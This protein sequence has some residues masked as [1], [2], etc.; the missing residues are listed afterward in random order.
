MNIYPEAEGISVYFQIKTVQK[1]EEEALR[2]CEERL[3]AVTK[4]EE[5]A[6]P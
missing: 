4:S 6:A 5:D 1:Q 2:E 3:R